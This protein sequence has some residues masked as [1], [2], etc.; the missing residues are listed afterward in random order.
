MIERPSLSVL[1]FAL[2][3]V[4]LAFH[5][6][7]HA[8]AC[9]YG[10]GRPGAIGMGLYVVWPVFY[11]DVTDSYR[12][13]RAGRLRTDLGGVYFNGIFA[14]YRGDD[15]RTGFEPLLVA[16]VAQHLIVLD[17]FF[18]WVRLGRVLRGGRPAGR[19]GS[20]LADQAGDRQPDPR[21]EPD[22]RVRQRQIGN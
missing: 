10:G 9:R 7:G 16:V 20:V 1:L 17:Q 19:L 11:T 5:E 6:G 22:P 12:F 14:L 2:A 4:S 13:G 8:A 15:L 3:Y 18:P 21:R